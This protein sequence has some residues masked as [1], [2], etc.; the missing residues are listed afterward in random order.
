MELE[1]EYGYDLDEQQRIDNE[2]YQNKE[3]KNVD[4]EVGK[5]TGIMKPIPVDELMLTWK[6]TEWIVDLF[7]AQGACVLLAG[8]MKFVSENECKYPTFSYN[9]DTYEKKCFAKLGSEAEKYCPNGK[10]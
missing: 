5:G 6:P 8:E 10:W 4:K 3:D 7:G 2:N 1:F 9:F